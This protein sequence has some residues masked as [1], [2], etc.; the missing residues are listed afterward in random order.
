MLQHQSSVEV[1]VHRQHHFDL[2][3]QYHYSIDLQL[4]LDHDR[5][6]ST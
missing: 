4:L 2:V 6:P 3:D 1:S 5:H